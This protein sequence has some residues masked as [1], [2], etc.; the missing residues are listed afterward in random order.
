MLAPHVNT[1]L[2]VQKIHF[3]IKYVGPRMHIEEQ[4]LV[5]LSFQMNGVFRHFPNVRIEFA[6]FA[7]LLC[8]VCVRL[9]IQGIGR[10]MVWDKSV[11]SSCHKKLMV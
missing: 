5:Y 2:K 10:F 9:K 4:A 7:N 6:L 3:S 8:M 1:V 11:T